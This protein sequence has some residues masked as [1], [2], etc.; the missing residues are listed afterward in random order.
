MNGNNT[1]F[2]GFFFLLQGLTTRIGKHWYEKR[3]EWEVR[4]KNYRLNLVGPREKK[5]EKFLNKSLYF[6]TFHTVVAAFKKAWKNLEPVQ[7][8]ILFFFLEILAEK[9]NILFYRVDSY[10]Y[11]ISFLQSVIFTWI[12]FCSRGSPTIFIYIYTVRF[13]QIPCRSLRLHLSLQKKTINKQTTN[14]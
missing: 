2:C 12:H 10:N 6:Q 5:I 1:K 8:P 11:S 7:Y 4:A 9:K 3:S 13:N 14:S